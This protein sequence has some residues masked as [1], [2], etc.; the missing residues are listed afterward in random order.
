[1]DNTGIY[2][3]IRYT[4]LLDAGRGFAVLSE[5]ATP[6]GSPLPVEAH[7]AHYPLLDLEL[8]RRRLDT[9]S[10]T[11]ASGEVWLLLNRHPGDEAIHEWA[12]WYF[13]HRRL[14][15]EIV[16]LL[17]E[18]SR[19]G[20]S[21]DWIYL[22]WAL[23][24]MR[25]GDTTEGERILR[26]VGTGARDWRFFANLGRIYED[27]RQISAA[28]S[29]YET[30]ALLVRDRIDAARIQMR[31]SRCLEALGRRT[32]SRAAMERALELDPDNLNIR[33]ELRRFEIR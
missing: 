10:P 16:R 27:R 8:L 28:L 23:A 11:R 13:E 14:Y 18:A 5:A 25:A 32:E 17:N 3:V 1:M 24:L 19:Q 26:E 4:R 30:A 9:W 20:M 6:A 29:A 15:S 7:I 2:S 12:A 21:G 22:H 31:I 33:R